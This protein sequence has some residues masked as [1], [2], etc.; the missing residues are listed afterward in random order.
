MW[1]T[2]KKFSF[3]LLSLSFA[4]IFTAPLHAQ[5]LL[6]RIVAVVNDEIILQSELNEEIQQAMVELRQRQITIPDRES[7]RQR[8]LDNMIMQT[9]QEERAR[10]RGLRV[11]DEE[12]NEQLLQ[13]AEANNL[14]L[15]QLI[16]ALNR[17]MPNGFAQVRQ[18]I[19]DQILIQKLREIEVI[20]QI[21]VTEQEVAHFIQRRQLEQN[22]FL[23]HLAHILIT[24]PDSPTREQR[25]ELENKVE[26]IHRRLRLGEDF[27]QLAVRY[28]EGSQALN[29][30]DLGRLEFD[31]IPSFFADAIERLQP[32]EISPIIE[33][34]SGYHIVK[35]HAL[36]ETGKERGITLEQEA[37]QA[38]RMRKA[39]ETFDLWLRR[40]RD[41]AYIDIKLNVVSQ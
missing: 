35:L 28:S 22:N 15:L 26:D 32:G 9:L 29:G 40:L 6:D 39:N 17:Q 12:V 18:E 1:Q 21:F 14:T 33:S 38:I 36:I 10:Q 24:R 30:G 34:P 23:Y 41:E 8:V 3:I 25:I 27:A 13:M 5:T 4:L 37:I 2:S 20:S 19:S 7:L 31:Q 16:D 11:S